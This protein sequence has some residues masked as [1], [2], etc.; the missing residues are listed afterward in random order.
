MEAI[1]RFDEYVAGNLSEDE[2]SALLTALGLYG[3]EPNSD[4]VHG[5]GGAGHDAGDETR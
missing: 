3:I 1:T 2:L 5:P 4:T